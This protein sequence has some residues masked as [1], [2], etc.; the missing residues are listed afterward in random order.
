MDNSRN[1]NYC[2]LANNV[3]QKLEFLSHVDEQIADAHNQDNLQAEISLRIIKAIQQRHI[4]LMKDF[5]IAEAS[6]S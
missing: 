4:N 3:I 6:A 5:L 1:K 2:K